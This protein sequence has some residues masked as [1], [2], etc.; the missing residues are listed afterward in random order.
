MASEAIE[1]IPLDLVGLSDKDLETKAKFPYKGA[2]NYKDEDSCLKNALE[3]D[4]LPTEDDEKS[5]LFKQLK[6]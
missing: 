4:F 1:D 3:E 5:N 2:K 6:A